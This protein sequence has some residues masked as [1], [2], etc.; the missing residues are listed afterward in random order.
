MAQQ[1][2]FFELSVDELQS[3]RAKY[4]ACLEAIATAGQSYTIGGRQFTRADLTV[5]STTLA[6]INNALERKQGR[7]IR[8]V[9]TDFSRSRGNL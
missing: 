9:Y 8:R 4:L 3:L 2:L 6:E 5:V 7:R 1:G